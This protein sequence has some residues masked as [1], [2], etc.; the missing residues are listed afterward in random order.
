MSR[1]TKLSNNMKGGV[2]VLGF[3]FSSEKRKEE[4]ERKE[5]EK[6]EADKLVDSIAKMP[7]GRKL[8]ENEY[9]LLRN[10]Y[11]KILKAIFDK[12]T[13]TVDYGSGRQETN[14]IYVKKLSNFELEEQ[15]ANEA[16]KVKNSIELKKKTIEKVSKIIKEGN[17][18]ITNDEY[19]SLIETDYVKNFKPNFDDNGNTLN[20]EYVNTKNKANTNKYEIEKAKLLAR[21]NIPG[22]RF[23]ITDFFR[24][25]ILYK[26]FSE[27]DYVF[28]DNTNE[29]VKN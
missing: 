8:N 15:K 22:E 14:I 20:F 9:Y 10:Y 24:L 7:G 4:K 5:R 25:K 3:E 6:K 19:E 11:P 27:N 17:G 2:K 12:Q 26:T 23:T 21:A 29:Y 28:D 16:K 1:K 13:E 18:N